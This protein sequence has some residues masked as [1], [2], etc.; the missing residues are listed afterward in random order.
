MPKRNNKL[1]VIYYSNY[2][3]KLSAMYFEGLNFII[4][5]IK[6]PVSCPFSHCTNYGP[7]LGGTP[8]PGRYNY[9]FTFEVLISISFRMDPLLPFPFLSFFPS[10]SSC[11]FT[12]PPLP[13]ANEERFYSISQS[14]FILEQKGCAY[15]RN[16]LASLGSKMT[17]PR[18]VLIENE[19]MMM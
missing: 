1:K 19:N 7:S 16:A 8:F 13:G 4:T 6:E 12:T 5:S 15:N 3:M 10:F 9:G 2:I 17:L 11:L 18:K 14:H